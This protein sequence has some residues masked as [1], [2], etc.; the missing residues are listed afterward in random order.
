MRDSDIVNKVRQNFHNI[1]VQTNNSV[2]SSFNYNLEIKKRNVDYSINFINSIRYPVFFQLFFLF[3]VTRKLFYSIFFLCFLFSIFFF[4]FRSFYIKV[5]STDKYA[6]DVFTTWKRT[7]LYEYRKIMMIQKIIYIYLYIYKWNERI[8]EMEGKLIS[9]HICEC[10]Q[11]QR[12]EFADGQLH[13]FR[14]SH[15]AYVH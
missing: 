14:R 1:I 6:I 8:N 9:T 11:R 15:H 5:R 12:E 3:N 2:F 10:S 4:C 13:L 7:R